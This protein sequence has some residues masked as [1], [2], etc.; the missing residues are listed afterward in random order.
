MPNAVDV[1]CARHTAGKK[2]ALVLFL[3]ATVL[4]ACVTYR[5][6]KPV[7]EAEPP[8]EYEKKTPDDMRDQEAPKKETAET[9]PRQ[10]KS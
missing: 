1:C 9:E 10:T 5:E 8:V 7:R 4:S 3:G 6:A 2:I